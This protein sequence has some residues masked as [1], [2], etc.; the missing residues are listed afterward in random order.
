MRVLFWSGMATLAPLIGSL[1][2]QP[3]RLR[4]SFVS[5]PGEYRRLAFR[6]LG[7]ITRRN[8]RGYV[9]RLLVPAKLFDAD[10]FPPTFGFTFELHRKISD[11]LSVSYASSK[12]EPWKPFTF[13][14]IQLINHPMDLGYL[15]N[16]K[17]REIAALLR[18]LGLE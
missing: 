7:A 8:P 11:S 4:A 10:T 9:V 5:T 3:L 13:G 17:L 16:V 6:E 2:V 1:K 12:L 18:D 14:Q 15:R